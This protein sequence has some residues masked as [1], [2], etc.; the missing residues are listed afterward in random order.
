MSTAV[1]TTGFITAPSRSKLCRRPILRA[2]PSLGCA[3]TCSRAPSTRLLT[4]AVA[5]LLYV[6]IPPIVDFLFINAVWTGT[7]RDACRA[8]TAGH[9]GRRL[10]GVRDRQDQLLHLRL[11]PGPPSAGASTS[12]S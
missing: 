5:Y 10:L 1:D 11:L 4:I 2:V 3:R 9:R 6:I 12:S 7:D 8:E